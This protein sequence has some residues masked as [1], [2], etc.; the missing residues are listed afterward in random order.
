MLQ[1][2]IY[3]NSGDVNNAFISYRNAADLFLR[4]DNTWYGVRLPEQLKKDVLRTAWQN[5]FTDELMRYEN[6]FNMKFEPGER[7]EGGELVLFWENG[8]APVKEEQNFF[9][10][11]TKN[12]A[13]NFVF[14]DATGSFN[15]P[16]DFRDNIKDEDIKL[17]DFRSFRVAFPRYVEQPLYYGNAIL[18]VNN[19][20]FHFEP[21]ENINEVAFAT[22]RERFLKEM[23]TAL[24]RL[25][26]KKIAEA[27]ARPKKDDKNKDSREALALAIQIFNFASEKA[28]TR[29]WQ[30]LPHT[31]Y[32][33]PY[34]PCPRRKRAAG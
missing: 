14:V 16:F 30:S 19:E 7:P 28:D 25:A 13:G 22:L 8:M 11:L 15:I 21:A 32:Y 26:V 33:T 23:A 10:T 17:E 6:I 20:T 27:A 3:E 31:I 9:F 5:G 2:I 34:T 24:S 18:E 29:N 4:N 1:G 12:G